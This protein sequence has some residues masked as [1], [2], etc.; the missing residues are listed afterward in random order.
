MSA[1][2]LAVDSGQSL[3]D[4]GDAARAHH[5]ITEGRELLPATRAKTRGVFLA[6]QA[7]SHL[8]S[9]ETELAAQA[10]DQA[11]LL[12]RRIGVPRC[13]SLVQGLVPDFERVRTT[14][15]VD[16]LLMLVAA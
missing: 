8:K 1:A 15:G 6:Y 13:E 16:D 2:D 3:L 12:A 7:A 14:E 11:L 9:K 10:A 4:L 5:L